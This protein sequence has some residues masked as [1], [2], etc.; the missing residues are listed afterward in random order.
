MP[1]PTVSPE[2]SFAQHPLDFDKLLSGDQ[3]EAEKLSQVGAD[4]V[5]ITL[6]TTRAEAGSAQAFEKI[7]R[8]YVLAAAQAALTGSTT[9]TM[10]TTTTKPAADKTIVYCSSQAANSSSLFLYPRSKGLTEEGLAK[11]ASDVIIFRPGFLAQAERK[12]PRALETIFGKLTGVVS[13]FSSNVEINVSTLGLAMVKAG[14]L[15]SAGL[16]SQ[17][18]GAPPA[19]KKDEGTDNTVTVV[20]N[21]E[22]IQLGKQ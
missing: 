12:Q 14:Q 2:K 10:T 4:V 15:G 9:T 3:A 19:F 1:T 17:G 13:H 18:M 5:F 8:Q 21:A 7:D 6:G 11:L 22:A 16:R 20:S